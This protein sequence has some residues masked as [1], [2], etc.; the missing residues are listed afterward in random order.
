MIDL[1]YLAVFL[2][3]L[4][5]LINGIFGTKIKNEK[6]IGLIGSGAIFIAFLIVVGAFFETLSLPADQR[7]N[8][9]NLF[10]WMKV[11]SLD[12]SFAYQVDQLSLVMALVVTGVGFIIH[13]YSIGYM[14]GDKAFWRFFAYLNL[15]IFAMMNLI[16]AD[17][18][19]LMFLGWEGVG[20]C[21]Y[22]LIGFWYDKDFEKST[23]SAAGLKAF[24]VN[25]IGDVGFLLGM[26]LI[27]LFFDS[28]RFS[29]VFSRAVSFDVPEHIFMLITLFLFIGATGKSAQIPL[30]VWLPDA[31]AG[32]TPVSALIHAATMVTAGVYMVART[33]VLYAMAPSTMMIVAVIGVFTAFFAAT[34]G[35]V[36]NDIKKV[37]AYSTISQLG[38]MFLAMGAGA[39]S[40][41]IFHLMTHAF[42]KALLFLGA[43]S[44]IHAMHEQQDIQQYG[45]LKKYMPITYG[46][47]LVAAMAI[48]G[49]PP[50][51]GFFSKDEILWFSYTNLGYVFW[52]I[53]VLTALMT[54]FYMFRFYFLTFNGKPRF[55]EK[56]TH[57]HES[58]KVMT[59][60]LIVL[61]V[62]SA[63]G[64]FIGIPEIFSGAHGNSFHTWLS[65]IFKSAELKLTYF[66]THSHFEEYLLMAISVAG[67]LG[68][69]SAAAY[70]YLKRPSIA[71]NTVE[72]FK[73]IY[74]TLWNK[75]YV[76]EVYDATVINPIV[77]SSRSFLWKIFDNK[78]IDGLVNGLARSIGDVSVLIRKMQTGIVQSYALVMM[79][80]ILLALFWIILS[81]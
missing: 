71:V 58:P 32:P 48:S 53:G 49:I 63:I 9:V 65:P 41:G 77:N 2:P 5:F 42:F 68:G 14:H 21:S 67:A 81:L 33:S 78:I 47:F 19:V 75:Y 24:V 35:L 73:L 8:Y 11:G 79:I 39:F 30:F 31:M 80:G 72:K 18:F 3:L 28:L 74:T 22:L 40:A 20:L 15:F 45:G 55:D 37:L 44:V 25:R 57:P 26:F 70:I 66:G 69:I 76:D 52:L 4:G 59:V 54:A 6:I 13:V 23:T 36:Q 34:I 29:E 1:I 10:T 7:T 46:T 27:Y 43:G 38:Y 62:L 12:V 16:M 61:A 56:Q 60:P 64:G 17:N 51:S 50:F